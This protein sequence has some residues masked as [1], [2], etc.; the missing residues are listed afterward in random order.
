MYPFM[1]LGTN[2]IGSTIFHLPYTHFLVER[3][4][5]QVSYT[6]HNSA[7]AY[8]EHLQP[9]S[10]ED[11]SLELLPPPSV[12]RNDANGCTIV[13]S[14]VNY[15]S[16]PPKVDAAGNPAKFP[17]SPPP[18]S[19]STSLLAPGIVLCWI[20]M[21]RWG[22]E[23]LMKMLSIVTSSACISRFH[24]DCKSWLSGQ[25]TERY[26]IGKELVQ[27]AIHPSVRPAQ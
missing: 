12:T 14:K 22:W 2:C 26:S 11:A 27:L 16:S 13:V 21:A 18:P 7:K 6:W 4:A 23:S 24:K 9:L 25:L 19:Q 20:S 17:E 8:A 15:G 10:I 3:Q 5:P 1:S